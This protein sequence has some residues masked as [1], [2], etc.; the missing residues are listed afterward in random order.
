M[1]NPPIHPVGIAIKC[2][3]AHSALLQFSLFYCFVSVQFSWVRVCLFIMLISQQ[4]QDALERIMVGRTSVIVAHR[5]SSIQSCDTIA[6]LDKG[7]VVEM[8][9]HSSLLAIGSIGIYHS[10]VNLQRTVN[11]SHH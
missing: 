5:L 2:R 9:N 3:I 11:T 1:Y 10:L 4:V 7:K 6:V 8:G